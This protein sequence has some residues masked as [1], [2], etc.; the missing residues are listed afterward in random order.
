LQQVLSKVFHS[1]PYLTAELTGFASD[2]RA[3]L[4]WFSLRDRFGDHGIVSVVSCRVF[5]RGLEEFIFL[6][7]V[8]AARTLG[9]RYLVGRYI[10]TRKNRPVADLFERLGFASDGMEDGASRWVLDLRGPLPG[11]SPFIRRR[12]PGVPA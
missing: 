9:F 6:E 8:Q 1:F 7:M 12:H 3:W 5:S 2:P 10:P 4:R 11:F